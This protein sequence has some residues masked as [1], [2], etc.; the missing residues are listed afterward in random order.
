MPIRIKPVH[1]LKPCVLD[2]EGIKGICDLIMQ[3]FNSAKFSAEDGVWEVFNETK[4]KFIS[5]ITQREKLDS[6]TV[7]AKNI[8]QDEV[9][10]QGEMLQEESADK[11]I[12]IRFD[13]HQ[14]KVKF[15]GLHEL[16]NWFEHFIIDLRK[17]LRPPQFRQRLL[18]GGVKGFV[19]TASLTIAGL[20]VNDL[21]RAGGIYC[22]I[23][24][25]K[26]PTNPFVESVKANLV[27]NLIW[28]V[29]VFVAGIL[30]TV[31]SI[32]IY[33]KFG[34]NVNE[35]LTPSLPTPTPGPNVIPPR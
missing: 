8:L 33:R 20:S 17:Q 3:N 11:V 30:F 25:H 9:V 13:K 15:T 7:K 12:R 29:L 2:L 23:I 22:Q 21:I 28:V 5:A 6:F 18:A 10:I 24:L 14:A 19:I 35:W 26:R 31:F 32:W 27:S 34:L 16:E 4:D 1:D